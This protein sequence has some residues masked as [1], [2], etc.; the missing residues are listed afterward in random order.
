MR[1]GV[2]LLAAGFPSQ[3]DGEVL[4]AAVQAAVA[5]ERAGFDDVWLAEHHFM[6]YGICPSAVTLAGYVLGQTERVDVGTAVSV[7][8]ARHPVALAEQAALLDQVSGGRFRLGVRAR[9]PVAGA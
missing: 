6:S 9:R 7:L 3:S 8:S 1:V 5:A 2:F 4:T